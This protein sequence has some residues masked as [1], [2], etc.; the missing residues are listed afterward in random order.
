LLL[1]DAL[2]L[3]EAVA[4]DFFTP[5]LLPERLCFVDAM[6][7]AMATLTIDNYF[8]ALSDFHGTTPSNVVFGELLMWRGARQNG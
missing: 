2:G 1:A 5:P 7:E 4:F 8:L 3:S 6:L